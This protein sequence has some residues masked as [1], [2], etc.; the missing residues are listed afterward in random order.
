MPLHGNCK[1][2]GAAS[3]SPFF[4]LCRLRWQRVKKTILG[5]LTAPALPSND[6]VATTMVAT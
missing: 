3:Q 4:T 6:D 5:S 1:D 2:L